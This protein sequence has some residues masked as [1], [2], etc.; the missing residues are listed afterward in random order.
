MQ[1]QRKLTRQLKAII[2]DA[3]QPL[4]TAV[5]RE[6]LEHNT[7]IKGSFLP[8]CNT[9]VKPAWLVPLFT[10]AIK[11]QY[12]CCKSYIAIRLLPL[13]STIKQTSYLKMRMMRWM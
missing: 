13:Q 7:V 6:A 3:P 12:K 9:A 11:Y 8:H 10:T 4:K 5:V 2:T 1:N